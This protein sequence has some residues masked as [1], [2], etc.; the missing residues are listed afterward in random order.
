MDDD[1]PVMG[2]IEQTVVAPEEEEIKQDEQDEERNEEIELDQ[3]S[4]T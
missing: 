3:K 1:G 4:I 2:S